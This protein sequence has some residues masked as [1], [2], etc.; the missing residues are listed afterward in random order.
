MPG[1]EEKG[2]SLGELSDGLNLI[3]GPNA[4]GKTTICRAIRGLLWPDTLEK[5]RSVFLDA[6][7]DRKGQTLGMEIEGGQLSCKQD[8]AS[9][10]PPDLP[11]ASLASCFTITVDD[12]FVDTKTDQGLADRVSR[13]MAGGYN[14]AVVR[15][16]LKLSARHGR[17][18]NN[19]LSKAKKQAR[20]IRA[21]QEKLR[22]EEDRLEEFDKEKREAQKAQNQLERLKDVGDLIKARN[23]I[24]EAE[25]TLGAFPKGM[26]RLAGNEGDNLKQI[27]DDLDKYIEA[28]RQAI[29]LAERAI[30]ADLPEDGISQLRLDEQ[31]THLE[32]LR[33]AESDLKQAEKNLRDAEKKAVTAAKILNPLGDEEKLSAIDAAG[34]NEIEAFH[35]QYE[36]A[37]SRQSA[38]EGKLA[39]FGDEEIKGNVDSLT[40]GIFLLRKW[41]ESGS[42][43]KKPVY[44][45]WRIMTLV[46]LVLLAVLTLF[47]VAVSP[48]PWLSAILLLVVGAGLQDNIKALI[49]KKTDEGKAFQ[50]QYARLDLDQPASWS[51]DGVGKLLTSLEQLLAQVQ[52][53][54][55][56]ENEKKNLQSELEQIQNR[57]KK[58]DSERVELVGRLGLGRETSA[59]AMVVLAGNLLK[60]QEAR[61]TCDQAAGEVAEL[62]QN[63]GRGLQIINAFLAEFGL[64]ACDSYSPAKSRIDSLAKRVDAE[65]KAKSAKKQI[66]TFQGR[67]KELF[68]KVGLDADDEAEL[69]RRIEQLD[70]FRN[71]GKKLDHLRG[72]ER[73]FVSRLADFP[74]LTNMSLQQVEEEKERQKILADSY[75][76]L[77]KKIS[78]INFRIDSAGSEHRLADAMVE[79]ERAGDALLQCRDEAMRKGAGIF[80]LDSVE[81]EHKSESQ[82]Q[83]FR[84]AAKWF[85][86]FTRG[87]YELDINNAATFYARDTI[88]AQDKQLE[89]LSR[90]TRMQLLLA[91]R[92]AFAA[93][94]ER[95]TQLPFV[96]DEVLSSSDPVRFRSVA[97]CVLTLVKEGRQVFYFTCQD[98]DAKAWRQVAD[99]MSFTDTQYIDLAEIQRMERAADSPLDESTIDI[100]PIPKPENMSLAE[101]ARSLGIAGLDPTA[102]AIGVHVAHLVD[103]AEQLYRLLT[104][105]IETF[106]PLESLA[107]HGKIDAYVSADAMER[108]RARA[109]VIDA[110][111]EAWKVGRGRKLSPQAL[112]DAG[113]SDTFMDRVVELAKKLDWNA[114][115]LIT[116][117][118][119]GEIK[120]FHK[121]SL[122]TLAENLS[123]A[124]YLDMREV[125]DKAAISEQVFSAANDHIKRG[126]IEIDQVRK[127]I[128]RHGTG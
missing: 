52:R 98:G 48:S 34:L 90:G 36:E 56:D 29:E 41:F 126:S 62:N 32:N 6:Q 99:E 120:R 101:Y 8:G 67:K 49:G 2:F 61:A 26:E 107:S 39:G 112:A 106:G 53:G 63:C 47:S 122:E 85:S 119:N 91:V 42:G 111:A 83:V 44:R 95:G 114:K 45:R 1:F 3:V 40:T 93:A 87:R 24:G 79:V 35:R 96:L 108:I 9:C 7:W 13:A 33:T 30:T 65:E 81:A 20:D 104:M 37:Q 58:L 4:S 21:E 10:D 125:L 43:S 69:A 124:G 54:Q 55:F 28:E 76:S 60:Y 118:E 94:S 14:L 127:I 110:F 77:L 72:A 59:M 97:E 17:N 80:L 117:M 92:L 113:V 16:E 109:C 15:E 51:A 103:E 88:A 100:K 89:E 121:N 70:D 57:M 105:S 5:R 38:I 12:L 64:E 102:G 11:D 19:D 123:E 22:D 73:N 84:Q 82:P 78:E 25:N 116:A 50:M 66:E 18:E 74:K 27:Q 31:K 75:E 71:A 68:R 46:L 128:E 115:K 86:R 23:E